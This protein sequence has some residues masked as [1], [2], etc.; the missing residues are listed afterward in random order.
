MIYDIELT[1]DAIADIEKFK[2]SGDINTLR[3]IDQLFNELRIHPTNGTGKPEKLKHYKSETWS[4]KITNKHRLV[5]RIE[6]EKII[7]L[8][9][10]L[11]GHYNDK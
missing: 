7:V 9:L 5:Y 2:K 8:I 4:R 6:K 10:S 11:W 1:E 3:K